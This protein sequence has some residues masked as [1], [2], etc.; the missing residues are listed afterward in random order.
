VAGTRIDQAAIGSCA[1]NR[2]DDMRAAAAILRDRKV[3]R[4]VT[5]YITPGSREVYAQAAREGLLEVFVAA[6]AT[7]LAPGCTTCWGYEGALCDNEVSISTHQMNYHGRNGSRSARSYLASPLR[8]GL[9]RRLPAGS[10]IPRAGPGGHAGRGGRMSET[11]M[12]ETRAFVDGCGSS[13]QH[14]RRRRQSSQYSKVPDLATF[15]IPRSSAMCFAE[16]QPGLSRAVKPGDLVVAGSNFGPSQPR[17]CLRGDEGIRHCRGGR[18]ILRLRLIRKALNV[19]LPIVVCPGVT[20]IVD[21]GEE[22]EV[23]LATGEVRQ[24]DTG[25]T[26]HA[27][28]FSRPDDR[29]LAGR[30]SYGGDAAAAG[31]PRRWRIS[32]ST[33]LS[34]EGQHMDY[35]PRTEPHKLAHDPVT[36][37]VVPR[38]IG[39]I[40]DHQPGR[41]GQSRTLLASSIS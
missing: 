34:T 13:G 23:D 18:G 16:L 20:R 40:H 1:A 11:R 25:A 33:R 7:V 5:M 38:P 10:P 6:G 26:L 12:H 24:T 30:Q 36:S 4:A 15:D 22:L 28:P 17:A 27:R 29:G 41:R 35:D 2:L 31:R 14:Q 8:C 9:P 19:G 39:W 21:Q 32:L 37:L 3:D